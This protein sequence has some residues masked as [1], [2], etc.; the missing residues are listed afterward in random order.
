MKVALQFYNI[1]DNPITSEEIDQLMEDYSDLFV[2]PKRKT[3]NKLKHR[4]WIINGKRTSL[5]IPS[6]YVGKIIGKK[7][8]TINKIK[9]T[10]DLKFIQFSNT[11][12]IYQCAELY[13]DVEDNRINA[14]NFIMN[15]LIGRDE[16][17]EKGYSYSGLLQNTYCGVCYHSAHSTSE[18]NNCAICFSDNH[19]AIDCKWLWRQ[20]EHISRLHGGKIEQNPPQ[21]ST[22]QFLKNRVG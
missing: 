3:K 4:L 15:V 1:N 18:C 13:G 2:I 21:T 9:E 8:T 20:Y 12:S 17:K 16:I 14:A 5:L 10:F 6:K 22:T 7:G 19:L 11:Y